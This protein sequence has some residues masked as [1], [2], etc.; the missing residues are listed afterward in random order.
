[1]DEFWVLKIVNLFISSLFLVGAWGARKGVGAWLNPMSISFLFWF[2]YTA[3]PLVVAFEV[4]V[5]PL[6]IVYILL[7]CTVFWN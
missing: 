5:S 1:M 6:A 2:L 7:F 3:F 4:P